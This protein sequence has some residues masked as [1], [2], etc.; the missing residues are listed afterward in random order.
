[1]NPFS[2]DLLSI[3]ALKIVGNCILWSE[4]LE[5]IVRRKASVNPATI[6]IHHLRDQDLCWGL[7]TEEA[8]LQLLHFIGNR[9]LLGYFHRFDRLLLN[10]LLL[11]HF[12]LTLTSPE[13]ELMSLYARSYQR[14]YPNQ[15][16]DLTLDSILLH[17]DL[18]QLP[19]HHALTDALT[20]ALAYLRLQ[21]HP[22]LQPPTRVVTP[23]GA[24]HPR[25]PRST[26]GPETIPFMIQFNGTQRRIIA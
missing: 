6:P 18:P 4:R 15:P 11:E 10:R 7:S 1:L 12:N 26:D 13:L 3:G 16:V 14:A 5:L 20:V 9:P 23:S 8:L 25:P 19:R 2:A 21:S 22:P 24:R 17:L